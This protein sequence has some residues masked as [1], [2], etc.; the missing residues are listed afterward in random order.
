MPE[1][2]PTILLDV[3]AHLVPVLPE[4]LGAFDGVAWDAGKGV[5]SVDGHPIG[6]KP[7]YDPAALLRWM[8]EQGVGHVWISAPPPTYRQQLRGAAARAWADYLNDGLARIAAASGGRLSALVHLP[9]EAPEVAAAIAAETIARGHLL[10][11]M[12]CG[13]GD[14]R[15]LG[16][17]E[18]EPLWQA[19]G[20][21]GAFVFFHPGECADGRLSA[22]YLTNLLGNPYESTVAIA[23]LVLSGV[24]ERHPGLQTCFAHGGGLT[25]SVAGRW[26]RGHATAR[27]G[28]DTT[29]EPP[30]QGLR[31]IMVDCICHGD[32]ALQLVE[33]TFGADHVVFGSDWPFPMGLVE[34]QRQMA[35]SAATR[36]ARIFSDNSGRLRA[37][38]SCTEEGS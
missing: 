26:Q 11:A 2:Q 27:P 18:F 7:L 9:T 31:R 38:Y 33:E 25:A 3:H 14:E 35:D 20:D 4:R 32:T 15:T 24:L 36:R 1:P 5:L 6:M 16:D 19:L 8:D 23:H 34:P 37:R 17:A 28:L 21:A 29:R 22:F 13:T 12:P 10:F 30:A